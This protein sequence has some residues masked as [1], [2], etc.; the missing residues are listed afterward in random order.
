VQYIEAG[1]SPKEI[2]QDIDACSKI[3]FKKHIDQKMATILAQQKNNIGNKKHINRKMTTIL[4]QQKNNIGN[5][6]N[7]DR[8]MTTILAQQK[9]NIGGNKKNQ[10]G[11]KMTKV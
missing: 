4:A 3:A 10:I 11:N 1:N 7:I 6:K 5:K 8:K 2:C 9:N